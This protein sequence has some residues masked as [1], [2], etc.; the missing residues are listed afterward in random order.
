MEEEEGPPH[1]LPRIPRSP[2]QFAPSVPHEEEVGC[3]LKL[4]LKHSMLSRELW[5]LKK[6]SYFQIACCMFSHYFWRM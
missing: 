2:L 5:H 4:K 3:S 6:E 1:I